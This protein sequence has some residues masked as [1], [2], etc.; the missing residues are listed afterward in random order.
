VSPDDGVRATVL[1]GGYHESD[2][3][4]GVEPGGFYGSE[5][6]EYDESVGVDVGDEV[7]L[8]PHRWSGQLTRVERGDRKISC[9][10]RR[11]RRRHN[12][13]RTRAVG[14]PDFRVVHEQA[15]VAGRR[16]TEGG[17]GSIERLVASRC[18]LRSLTTPMVY[19]EDSPRCPSLRSVVESI[20]LVYTKQ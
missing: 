18:P 3:V 6:T 4:F 7:P 11:W 8:L 5:V 12:P 15:G 20:V 13:V 17:R 1:L 10:I 2:E 9:R 14:G 16:T 19:Y